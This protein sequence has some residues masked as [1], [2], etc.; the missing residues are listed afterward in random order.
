MDEFNKAVEDVWNGKSPSEHDQSSGALNKDLNGAFGKLTLDDESQVK[1]D[2]SEQ[3]RI[4]IVMK[5][6]D[7]ECWLKHRSLSIIN[8]FQ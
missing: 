8:F 5:H 7:R 6:W 4:R 2:H 3:D 1:D